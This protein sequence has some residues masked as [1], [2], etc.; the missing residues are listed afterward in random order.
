MVGF[1][2]AACHKLIRGSGDARTR[3]PDAVDGARCQGHLHD[4]NSS[5]VR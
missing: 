4:Q 1:F 2:S 3:M 5:Q